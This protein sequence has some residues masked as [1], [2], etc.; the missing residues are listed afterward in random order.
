MRRLTTFFVTLAVA[1]LGLVWASSA[2][3]Q[4][5][6]TALC[7]SRTNPAPDAVVKLQNTAYNP[8]AVT[9]AKAGMSVCW[10]HHDGSTPHSVT[11]DEPTKGDID[12][13][14]GCD[15]NH[16]DQCWRETQPNG[17]P[18]P[19]N[20]SYLVTFSTTG[21]FHYHCKIHSSMQG[22]VT[23]GGGTPPANTTTTAAP[24]GNVTTT[25]K[26]STDTTV[27]SISTET[28]TGETTTTAEVTTTTAPTTAT[29]SSA[30]GKSSS[31]DDDEPSVLLKTIGIVLLAAVVAAL[32]PSWRRLT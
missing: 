24:A 12:S 14:P 27:G 13:H 2:H 4:T 17:S 1:G 26:A 16:Q 15:I 30:L 19:N 6:P 32:I 21:T 28:T 7:S 22:T 23:V 10:E 29:T 9:L 25:T 18:D 8:A 31:N 5:N 3:A 11:F 20:S